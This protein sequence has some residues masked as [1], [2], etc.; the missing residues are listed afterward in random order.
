MKITYSLED[1]DYIDFNLYHIQ[2]TEKTKNKLVIQR[3]TGTILFIVAGGVM[4]YFANKFQIIIFAFMAIIGI[5][6]FINFPKLANSRVRK[7]TEKALS[8][9]QITSLFNQLTLELTEGGILENNSNGE[10]LIRWDHVDSSVYTDEYIYLILKDKSAIII[11]NRILNLEELIQL[12][13]VI[14]A[15]FI[16]SR[17]I[18]DKKNNKK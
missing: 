2:Y 5:F 17:I 8:K 10:N 11:P 7:S 6:W 18:I 16:G 4:S 13:S 9:A 1:K 15:S 12:K 14:D 3:I